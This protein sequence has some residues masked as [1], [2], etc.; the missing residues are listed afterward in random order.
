MIHI[1]S[2]L[3]RRDSARGCVHGS[4]ILSY[5]RVSAYFDVFLDADPVLATNFIHRVNAI[6]KHGLLYALYI[7]FNR[8]V[9]SWL[10]RFAVM[11]VYEIDCEMLCSSNRLQQVRCDVATNQSDV[12]A[13]RNATFMSQP[14]SQVAQHVGYMASVPAN[15]ARD[16]G[17]RWELVGGVWAGIEEYFED[18]FGFRIELSRRQAWIYCAYVQKAARG[19]GVYAN[20]LTFAANDL[21]AKGHDSILFSVM[22]WNRKSMAAHGRVTR[23][24]LGRIVAVRMLSFACVLA[25]GDLSQS[26]WLTTNLAARPVTIHL[27]VSESGTG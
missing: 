26:T 16:G 12:D 4:L 11:N 22:P 1:L 2:V 5:L 21:I 7:I 23:G 15:A 19:K 25:F 3:R 20:V 14:A 17:E 18:E 27:R 13:L 24:R 9:P 6:Q 8:L 10:F